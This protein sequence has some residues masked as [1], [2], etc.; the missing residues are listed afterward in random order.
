MVNMAP[1]KKPARSK[2]EHQVKQKRIYERQK[3]L[4]VAV[5]YCRR[6]NFRGSAAISAGVCPDIKDSRTINK[7]L[8]GVLLIGKE[9][10]YCHVLTD[11][12]EDLLV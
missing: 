6:N 3:H 7:R 12:E 5:Q 4:R 11:A 9:K 8:D 10:E 2:F 1:T